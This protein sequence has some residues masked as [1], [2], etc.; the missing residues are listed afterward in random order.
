MNDAGEEQTKRTGFT[1]GIG[2]VERVAIIDGVRT[3]FVKAGGV[4]RSASFL[5]LG[6]HV[7]SEV[8][9]RSNINPRE[10]DELAFGTV[11][12]DPRVPNAA[13]ELVFR[14]GLPASLSAH[15]VSNNC[16]TGLV[17]VALI[18][19]GIL[20]G[21]ISCGIAAGSESMS[22]PAL[23]LSKRAELFYLRLAA[24]RDL[25]ARMK[26]LLAFRL[27][28]LFPRPPSPKEPST[29]LTMGEHCE[30]MAK[31][32]AID[33]ESQ[34]AWAFHS[35]QKAA[36]ALN[37]GHLRDEIVPF[38]DVNTDGLI[39]PDTSIQKLSKLA[40]VFDR[41]G[42][43]TLTA[44][45]SSALTDGA[46]AV[47]LM[48]ESRARSEGRSILGFIEAIEFS[49]LSPDDG[50]LMAPGICL[51]K[52]LRRGRLTVSDIDLFEIHEAFAAQ[53][54]CNLQVWRKGWA[55]HPLAGEV[56][57]IPIDKIN[58][59]GGSIA[60]G[61]PFAATGGRL[62]SSAARELQRSGKNRAVISI[63]AAGAM[64]GAVLISR[65]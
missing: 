35:H 16:I 17:A 58:L 23:A 10:I 40:P 39:R 49:A 30:I 29:G 15:F 28:Y 59:N 22:Q 51:P 1:R 36:H 42:S 6:G 64:A 50:L 61:H 43:G 45:N 46:A 27:H 4:F 41:S 48:A 19:E 55:K 60:L 44:G 38:M 2:M 20:S 53:V 63:C 57:E 37:N 7:V 56:G 31:E 3:P 65:E 18:G 34:D 54:L 13:R 12:L 62:V 14:C 47:L 8:V 11:L 33:R 52:L 24:A 32:F 25:T 26:A 9:R 21:R 5:E